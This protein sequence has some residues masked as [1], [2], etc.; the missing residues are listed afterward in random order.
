MV[1]LVHLVETGLGLLKAFHN[2]PSEAKATGGPAAV[3]SL[4]LSLLAEIPVSLTPMM[5]SGFN[6]KQ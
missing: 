1:A 4:C 2:D 5:L 3:R 6:V